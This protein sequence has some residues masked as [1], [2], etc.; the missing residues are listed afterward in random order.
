LTLKTLD[1]ASVQS[2]LEKLRGRDEAVLTGGDA[3]NGAVHGA[4]LALGCDSQPRFVAFPSSN[5]PLTVYY[6]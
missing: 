1:L 6:C 2:A 3:V 5:P 4:S